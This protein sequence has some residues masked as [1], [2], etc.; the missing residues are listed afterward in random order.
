MFLYAQ[1]RRAAPSRPESNWTSVDSSPLVPPVVDTTIVDSVCAGRDGI[2]NSVGSV[3]SHYGLTLRDDTIYGAEVGLAMLAA[4]SG[5]QAQVSAVNTIVRG[6]T[7]DVEAVQSGG[8]TTTVD[9]DHS[10][11]ANVK[12]EGGATVTAAGSGTNQTAAALLTNVAAGN[13]TQTAASPTIDAGA[14]DAANGSLD[15]AGNS[16]TLAGRTPCSV[17]TDI[18]AYEYAPGLPPCP[19]QAP[20]PSG[21]A[22]PKTKKPSLLTTTILKAKVKELTARFRFKG[23]DA[24]GTGVKFECKLDRMKYHRCHSPK[25]YKNLKPGKHKFLV[26]AVSANE[27]D[28]TPA[29]RKFR[30]QA[31]D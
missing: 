29:K 9:L 19:P 2:F 12:T 16:R 3:G 30:I 17:I 28:S 20:S 23:T 15:L 26:R 18:G 13:F 1:R 5:A 10:N 22:P 11:Y 24:S 14:N 31:G 21:S 25:A 4:A 6:V 8:A 27:V 7:K